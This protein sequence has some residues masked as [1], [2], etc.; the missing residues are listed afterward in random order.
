[1]LYLCNGFEKMKKNYIHPTIEITPFYAL[2]A[3]CESGGEGNINHGGNPW[4]DAH[5]P[6]KRT[7]VF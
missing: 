3:L 2:T 7:E 6:R 5:S 1:M 4:D